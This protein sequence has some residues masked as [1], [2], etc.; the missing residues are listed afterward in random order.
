MS[1]PMGLPEGVGCDRKHQ[2]AKDK[3]T[4]EFWRH[5]LNT[6]HGGAAEVD[7]EKEECNCE[8]PLLK[9]KTLYIAL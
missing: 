8:E 7:T 1:S 4:C 3:I 6:L 2:N 9:D 5:F